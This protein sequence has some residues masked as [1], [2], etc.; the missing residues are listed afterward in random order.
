M[1]QVPTSEERFAVLSSDMNERYS[2]F[3]PIMSMAWR[4]LGWR[5]L[6][7]LVGERASWENNAKTKFVLEMT[8]KEDVAAFITP[9]AG[10]KISTT[11]QLVRLLAAALP[12]LKD[13]DYLLTSDVDMLPLNEAYFLHQDWSMRFNLFGADAYADITQGLFPPKFPMCYIGARANAWKDMMKLSS[14][15]ISEEAR[16]ALLGR[17]DTWDNDEMYFASKIF[18]HPCFQGNVSKVSNRSYRKGECELLIRTWPGGRAHLRLDRDLW[19]FD[20]RDGMIDCHCLRPGYLKTGPLR[21]V[22]AKNFPSDVAWFD[23]Y[24]SQYLKLVAAH[25]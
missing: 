2:F 7:L 11:A 20:A 5:P 22:I 19:G 25:G 10:Y 18:S 24:L 6:C 13:S 4:R 3:V 12:S 9:V 15:D 14:G 8:P 16:K 1:T 23:S 21:F 17:A